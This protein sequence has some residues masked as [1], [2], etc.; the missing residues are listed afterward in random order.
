MRV[1]RKLNIHSRA[2]LVRL[3]ASE[4]APAMLGAGQFW[5]TSPPPLLEGRSE[6]AIA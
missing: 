5:L 3:F 4:G 6:F 2:K 1:Y